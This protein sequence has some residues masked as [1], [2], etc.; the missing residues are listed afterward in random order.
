MDKR[1]R[2]KRLRH[3]LMSAIVALIVVFVGVPL[4]AAIGEGS[5]HANFALL[6]LIVGSYSTLY[7][8]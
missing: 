1:N 3:V 5:P 4:F 7:L 6:A 2:K 8:Y